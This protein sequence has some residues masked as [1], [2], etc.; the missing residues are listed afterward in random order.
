MPIMV[1]SI[2]RLQ[3]FGAKKILV[4]GTP[5]VGE[6]PVFHNTPLEALETA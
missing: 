4:I 2:Q 5:N 6:T 3:E 1:D